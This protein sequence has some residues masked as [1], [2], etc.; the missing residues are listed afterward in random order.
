MRSARL[1]ASLSAAVAYRTNPH[2]D[3]FE[4][5]QEAARLLRTMLVEGPG[6]VERVQ[7]PLVPSATSQLIQ[8]RDGG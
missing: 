8:I 5:G 6:V 7:L 4:R 1:S 3:L 2:V